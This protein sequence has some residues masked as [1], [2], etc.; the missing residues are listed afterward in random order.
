MESTMH[1]LQRGGG[2]GRPGAD[3]ADAIDLRAAIS[4]A[5]TATPILDDRL[6][7]GVW[8]YVCAERAAG[9]PPADVIVALTQLVG[10]ARIA[11]PM[12]RRASLRK[13][14]TWSVEA[15]FSHLGGTGVPGR[16]AEPPATDPVVAGVDG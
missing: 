14:V 9:T 13:V 3:L 4:S 12:V 7:R 10:A 6:R 2:S 11:D 15:Y 1:G 16:D 8:T 5:L